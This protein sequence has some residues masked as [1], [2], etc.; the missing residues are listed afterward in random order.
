[1]RSL[2]W[3]S[4]WNMPHCPKIS[5]FS[6]NCWKI[7]CNHIGEICKSKLINQYNTWGRTRVMILM[8]I[9]I[10]II[11]IIISIFICKRRF[12]LALCISVV[13]GGKLTYVNLAATLYICTS[14]PGCCVFYLSP[15]R[16]GRNW[17]TRSTNV[18]QK[19]VTSWK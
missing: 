13:Y 12:N 5:V 11:T 9:M 1:M 17:N 6:N 15:V 3:R 7:I 19:T 4:S 14:S 16:T 18:V 10:I 8:K 2:N